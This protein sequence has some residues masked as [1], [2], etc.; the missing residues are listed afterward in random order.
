[1]KSISNQSFKELA[2]PYFKECIDCID[3]VM[4]ECNVPYYLIGASAIALELLKEGIKR[5]TAKSWGENE[6]KIQ[7]LVG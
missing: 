1:M 3:E 4:K 6:I 5:I 2:I 7:L